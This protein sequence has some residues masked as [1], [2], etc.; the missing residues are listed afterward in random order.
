MQYLRSRLQKAALSRLTELPLTIHCTVTN[1]HLR[2]FI[3]TVRLNHD[4]IEIVVA[5]IWSDL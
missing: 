1:Y 2:Q 3:V 4:A 5:I